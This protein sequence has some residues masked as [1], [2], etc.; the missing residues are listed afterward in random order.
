MGNHTPVQGIYYAV[1]Q[2]QY[3]TR[4][5]P[6]S[7]AIEHQCTCSI[8]PLVTP[9]NRIGEQDPSIQDTGR[10][11]DGINGEEILYEYKRNEWKGCKNK[12]ISAFHPDE[13]SKRTQLAALCFCHS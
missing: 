4:L 12:G 9:N 10:Q 3:G 8:H 6:Q 1:L 5:C 2:L 13:L 7:A 11:V